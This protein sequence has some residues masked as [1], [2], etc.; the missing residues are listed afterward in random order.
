M[1][2]KKKSE[3]D[4]I[5]EAAV[6]R[7]S[8][9]SSL[10]LLQCMMVSLFTRTSQSADVGSSFL[11]AV[12]YV[13][14]DTYAA[15]HSQELAA[16]QNDSIKAYLRDCA[17]ASIEGVAGDQFR[18]YAAD[19]T[20]YQQLSEKPIHPIPLLEVLRDKPAFD[21]ILRNKVNEKLNELID[22]ISRDPDSVKGQ[23]VDLLKDDELIKSFKDPVDL[24]SVS[25][26]CG[27]CAGIEKLEQMNGRKNA[28][29]CIFKTGELRPGDDLEIFSCYCFECQSVTRFAFDPYNF[30]D[31]ADAGI[32]YFD[33]YSVELSDV[34]NALV[35]LRE[36]GDFTPALRLISNFPEVVDEL[37]DL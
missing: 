21:F 27:S 10:A 3:N 37:K 6:E 1:F 20:S 24:S 5:F 23:V 9:F 4:I 8:F 36:A 12:V 18:T 16:G 35:C 32:E 33:S 15:L 28:R 17:L 29:M 13:Y 25:L 7:I 31:N 34:K 2:W 14:Y 11:K 30:S 26:K 22:N 19:A